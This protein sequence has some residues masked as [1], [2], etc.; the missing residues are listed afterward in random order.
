[1]GRFAGRAALCLEAIRYGD[2]AILV[3]TFCCCFSS[4]VGGAVLGVGTTVVLADAEGAAAAVVVVTVGCACEDG[5]G[6]S[7]AALL[8][9][10]AV[11]MEGVGFTETLDTKVVGGAVVTAGLTAAA[12]AVF[13][14]LW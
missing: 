2:G 10:T 6:G 14:L 5:G 9:L 1:M 8:G 13:V 12:A 3:W 11:G 7:G 4:I